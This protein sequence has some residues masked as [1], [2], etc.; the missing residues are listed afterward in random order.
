VWFELL[1]RDYDGSVAFYRTVFGWDAHTMSDTAELRYTTLGEGDDALAGIMDGTGNLPGGVPSHW[2]V[3][4]G[5]EDT[6]KAV[7]RVEELGGTVTSPPLD[8]P[9]GRLASVTDPTGAAFHLM[10]A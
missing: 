7:V 2:A 6:D 3:Y 1:T 10:S 8:S 9:Y 4:L 5:V